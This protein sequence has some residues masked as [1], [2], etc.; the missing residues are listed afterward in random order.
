MNINMNININMNMN[1]NINMNMNRYYKQDSVLG[2]FDEWV[3]IECWV[4][5]DDLEEDARIGVRV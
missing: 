5:I 4:F 2:E 3:M 1:M